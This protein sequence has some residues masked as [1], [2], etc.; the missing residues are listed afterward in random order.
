ML[1]LSRWK[2]WL[3]FHVPKE[4]TRPQKVSKIPAAAIPAVLGNTARWQVPAANT[5]GATSAKSNSIKITDDNYNQYFLER[6]AVA[7]QVFPPDQKDLDQ[8]Q[9]RP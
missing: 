1:L 5:Q 7:I 4:S 8:T 6:T 9:F 2:Q 3:A